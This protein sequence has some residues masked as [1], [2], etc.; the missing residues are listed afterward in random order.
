[1]AYSECRFAGCFTCSAALPKTGRVHMSYV[2]KEYKPCNECGDSTNRRQR[3]TRKPLCLECS[4]EIMEAN[5]HNMRAHRGPYHDAWIA[6]MLK[7]AGVGGTVAT[8][9]YSAGDSSVSVV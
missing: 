8:P 3:R 2:V 6:G 1:M 9:P 7:A 5:I 4:T